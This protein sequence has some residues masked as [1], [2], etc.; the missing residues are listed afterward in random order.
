MD[1]EPTAIDIL[2]KAKDIGE[3]NG[4]RYVYLGNVLEGTETY[5]Y[6][7]GKLLMSR[8][9][10]ADRGSEITNGKCS[11]CSVVIAGVWK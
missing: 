2:R 5:C 1:H 4:L 8:D 11:E 6:K 10:I 9:Y 3:K 7:C